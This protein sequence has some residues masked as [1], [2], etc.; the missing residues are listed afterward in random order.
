MTKTDRERE[1]ERERERKRERGEPPFVA[2]RGVI[3]ALTIR[4]YHVS[5]GS[6]RLSVTFDA[7]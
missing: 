3:P 5:D 2:D 4:I 7:D 1:R 6:M